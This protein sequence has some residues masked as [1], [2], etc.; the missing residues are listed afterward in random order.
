MSGSGCRQVAHLAVRNS[1]LALCRRQLGTDLLMVRAKHDLARDMSGEIE[2]RS[3][4]GM[5]NPV[6]LSE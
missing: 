6:E 3:R 4:F 2:I 1:P 5:Q